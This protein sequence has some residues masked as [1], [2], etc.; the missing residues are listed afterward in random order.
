MGSCNGLSAKVIEWGWGDKL[1][2]Q[3]LNSIT[4]YW[5]EHRRYLFSLAIVQCCGWWTYQWS[6]AWNR[7]CILL[8]LIGGDRAS[9]CAWT[10]LNWSLIRLGGLWHSLDTGRQW[11]QALRWPAKSLFKV[12]RILW[13]C[14][15]LCPNCGRVGLCVIFRS[16]CYIL[17]VLY[18]T[19]Y[20]YF[21]KWA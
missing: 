5:M 14:W 12:W 17:V 21:T 9:A 19:G 2:P 11:L 13:C 3:W 18:S 10:W 20:R 4:V 15:V 1:H 8:L 16:S 7:S 6:S